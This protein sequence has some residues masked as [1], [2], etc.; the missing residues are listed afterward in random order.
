MAA[1]TGLSTFLGPGDRADSHRSASATFSE[2][3]REA[4][5]L[6]DVDASLASEDDEETAK[7]LANR[8]RTLITR[9]T[10]ADQKAP[11]VSINAKEQAE[12]KFA[13]QF[14]KVD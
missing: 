1:L 13:G 6:R 9:I 3:R 14:T 4:S 11:G 5:L 12:K 8:L 10:E 7:E 2:I